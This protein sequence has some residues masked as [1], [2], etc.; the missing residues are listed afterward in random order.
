MPRLDFCRGDCVPGI[1]AQVMVE[2]GV[3]S[4]RVV[5]REL[6]FPKLKLTGELGLPRDAGRGSR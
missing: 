1:L 2:C 6:H 5:A 3:L 4:T